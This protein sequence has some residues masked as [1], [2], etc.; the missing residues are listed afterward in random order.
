MTNIAISRYS[1]LEALPNGDEIREDLNLDRRVCIH[2]LAPRA[3]RRRVVARLAALQEVR[4]AYLALVYDLVEDGTERLGIVEEELSVSITPTDADLERRLYQLCAGLAS[5][6]E[7]GLAHGN[8]EPQSFRSDSGDVGRLCNLSF[9]GR[10]LDDP[11]TDSEGL[12]RLLERMGAS[13]IKDSRFQQYRSALGGSGTARALGDRLAAILLSDQHRALLHYRGN[14]WELSSSKRS[15]RFAHPAGEVASLSISYDGMRFFLADVQGE[16]RVNNMDL[17]KGDDLPESC[18]IALGHSH[19]QWY[20]RHF[21]TFDQS[22]PEV[23]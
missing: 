10:G 6:H 20:E 16:V 1:M 5:L 11:E 4:S 2:W 22:H 21:I 15:A 14:T 3:D 7:A 8:L 9:D 23:H 18:V 13:R 19:R 12:G 17:A